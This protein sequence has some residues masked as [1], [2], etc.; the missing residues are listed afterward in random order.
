MLEPPVLVYFFGNDPIGKLLSN[1]AWT[2]FVLDGVA[3]QSVEGFWQGLKS[4]YEPE[5]LH[6]ARLHGLEAK[7]AGQAIR[8]AANFL[9]YDQKMYRVAS[10]EHHRL[11][12]RALRAKFSQCAAAKDALLASGNRPLKHMLP[13]SFGTMRPGDS[14]ALPASVFEKM[15]TTIRT[16]LQEDR[17][18]DYMPIPAGL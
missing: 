7:R 16:E 14:P 12:E 6:F 3:Y 11:L 17:F 10:A 9:V 18:V 15:L 5:R 4:I 2:P 1:F 8:A 13:N